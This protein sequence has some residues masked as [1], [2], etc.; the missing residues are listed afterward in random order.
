MV[1]QLLE[2]FLI[3]V[4]NECTLMQSFIV[5]AILSVIT[6]E[7]ICAQGIYRTHQAKPGT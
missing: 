4:G 6:T 5:I 1:A 3:D 2:R 7:T